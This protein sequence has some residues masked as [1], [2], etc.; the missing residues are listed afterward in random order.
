M[1]SD[2]KLI[3]FYG[4]E[5]TG[6][7][8]MAKQLAQRYK[9]VYVPEVAR[10]MITTNDFTREDIIRIGQA[11]TARVLEMIQ[12]ADKI[13]FCDTDL[14]TT[15]I[16]SHHYLQEVPDI[17]YEL[18]KQVEYDHYFLFDI[19]VPWI[20]DGLRDLGHRRKEMFE[21]F[22]NALEKREIQY[23]LV[24]GNWKQRENTIISAVEKIS[25]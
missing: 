9:T 3:C 11:Q 15:Q 14:I 18:E 1:I 5:S 2:I 25:G 22:Q 7:T 12:V 13:L 19:D 20:S 24:K 23:T 21:I 16:Y 17:L 8:A 6:K 4:P 10:E